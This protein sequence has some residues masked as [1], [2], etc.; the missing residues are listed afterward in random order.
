MERSDVKYFLHNLFNG[1]DY[2]GDRTGFGPYSKGGLIR[3]KRG[4]ATVYVNP[5]NPSQSVYIKGVSKPNLGAM[6]FAL[7]L[8]LAGLFLLA[9]GLKNI[10]R[11]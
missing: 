6:A 5:E 1:I 11:D 10:I 2:S 7:A 3:P 9:L 8:G 4:R